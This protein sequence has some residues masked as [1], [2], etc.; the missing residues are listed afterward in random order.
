MQNKYILIEVVD[1]EMSASFYPEL[2]DAR[3]A[4]LDA[5]LKTWDLEEEYGSCGTVDDCIR[6]MQAAGVFDDMNYMTKY[7]GTA[8]RKNSDFDWQI[9]ALDG[10]PLDE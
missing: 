7:S 1:R 10:T 6:F 5:F 9:F 8:C 3:R 2:E 4:M